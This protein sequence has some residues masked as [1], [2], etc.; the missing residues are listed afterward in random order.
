[1]IFEFSELF[2]TL[3]ESE[4]GERCDKLIC[5]LEEIYKISKEETREKVRLYRTVGCMSGIALVLIMW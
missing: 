5:D 4:E 1:L 3:S 2:G